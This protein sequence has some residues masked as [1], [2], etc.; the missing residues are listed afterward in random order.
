[1]TLFRAFCEFRGF[2]D[3]WRI[4]LVMPDFRE[5]VGCAGTRQVSL[6]STLVVYNTQVEAL[7]IGAVLG[8]TF[9]QRCW[10]ANCSCRALLGRS[11]THRSSPRWLRA[12]VWMWLGI[13]HLR[14]ACL[15]CPVTPLVRS[16][17]RTATYRSHQWN[18][19]AR[20]NGL[21]RNH[22][23]G[24]YLRPRVRQSNAQLRS[25]GSIGP[26]QVGMALVLGEGIQVQEDLWS[27]W[28]NEVSSSVALGPVDARTNAAQTVSLALDAIPVGT[29]SL[30]LGANRG[31]GQLYPDGSISNLS[32]R[33]TEVLGT[34]AAVTYLPKRFGSVVHIVHA[35]GV[36]LAHLLPGQ[37][38]EPAI[39]PRML[40]PAEALLARTLNLGGFG[41]AEVALSVQVPANLKRFIGLMLLIQA[42]QLLLLN[43]KK[44]YERLFL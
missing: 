25:D 38:V 37:A 11:E 44:Q 8:L 35:E 36:W 5:R 26:L 12:P 15:T 21:P 1:M 43:K 19:R 6:S 9:R 27:S 14:G 41:L 4:Y 16:C 33:K 30:Y 42:T 3:F 34:C 7:T 2:P 20:Y 17:E 22:L 23:R 13:R 40:A 10:I 28:S 32:L 39:G 31:R 29:R 18:S 24:Q